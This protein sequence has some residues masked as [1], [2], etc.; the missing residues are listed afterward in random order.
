MARAFAI[1]DAQSLADVETA[2]RKQCVRDSLF[3]L[4]SHHIRD[5][6]SFAELLAAFSKSSLSLEAFAAFLNADL[7]PVTILAI[8]DADRYP[9]YAN[10]V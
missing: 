3:N 9:C 2:K 10:L 8:Q 1:I 4:K 5:A 6:N 7:V